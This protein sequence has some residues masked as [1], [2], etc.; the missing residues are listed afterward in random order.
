MSMM[1]DPL[2]LKEMFGG[3]TSSIISMMPD[4]LGISEMFGGDSSS[5]MSMMPD[6]LGLK[7]MFGGDSET[8]DSGG[9][10]TK[11]GD[12]VKN[13]PKQLTTNISEMFGLGEGSTEM[14]G[15]AVDTVSNF[16]SDDDEISKNAPV[17]LTSK[18]SKMFGLGEG[19]TEMLG[20]FISN[21]F[22]GDMVS[23]NLESDKPVS[24]LRDAQIANNQLSDMDKQSGTDAVV[25][26]IN[27]SA[28][29]N[30]SSNNTTIV[31]N[32]NRG[33]D[34]LIRSMAYSPAY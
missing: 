20:G 31:N 30:T 3:D 6:P 26:A 25:S 34:D 14:V 15:S 9:V 19:S 18:I 28:V 23:P 17:E 13:D 24:T 16:F 22:P 4:P 21:L 12:L 33:I 5:I 11:I 27:T 10:I 1:P 2:G 29:N 8:G 7:E 32:N